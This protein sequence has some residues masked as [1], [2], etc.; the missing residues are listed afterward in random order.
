MLKQKIKLNNNG[1]IALILVIMVT[2]LTL[3]SALTLALINISDLTA[4]YHLMEDEA[5]DIQKT[6]CIEDALYKISQNVYATGTYALNFGVINCNYEISATV[7][8]LKTVTSTAASLSD[9]G[10]WQGTVVSQVNVSSTP[11]QLVSYKDVIADIWDSSDWSRRIRISVQPDQVAADMYNFPVYVNLN[12]LGDDFFNFVQSDAGDLVVTTGDGSTKLLRE[13]ESFGGLSPLSTEGALYFLAPYLSSQVATDFYIY[14]GNAAADEQNDTSVWSNYEMVQHLD[15]NPNTGSPPHERDSTDNANDLTTVGSIPNGDSVAAQMYRGIDFDTADGDYFTI[16]NRNDFA[17]TQGTIS[18]WVKFNTL[19]DTTLFHL[20][21]TATTDYIRSYYSSASQYLDLIIEDG[22][23]PRINVRYFN[24]DTNG[25]HKIDWLQ[26]GSSVKLYF[27]GQQKALTEIVQDDSWWTDH[28]SMSG[29]RM[30]SGS[31]GS[32]LN[33]VMDEFRISQ[34]VLSADWI[35]TEYNN[36]F[37]ASS[38][39]STS[40]I[41]VL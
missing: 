2:T 30:G 38:F 9:L 14:F 36:Q 26:D 1:N 6:A 3:V 24:P 19:Q 16:A 23:T 13:V 17:S 5:V 12:D 34:R 40:T 8:G 29:A 33:G 21:E 20:Y 41:E 15:E 27:D 37:D 4:N 28:L 22:D 25:F 31:W 39:Y 32:S 35:L 7:A 18:F 10:Y 11:I